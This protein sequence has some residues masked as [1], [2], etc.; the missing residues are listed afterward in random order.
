MDLIPVKSDHLGDRHKGDFLFLG[1]PAL[2]NIRVPPVRPLPYVRVSIKSNNLVT[3]QMR[4]ISQLL[5]LLPGWIGLRPGMMAQRGGGDQQTDGR[6]GIS[7]H[8]MVPKKGI[9]AG[10]PP[11]PLLRAPGPC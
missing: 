1:T 2:C 8:S 5:L 6:D 10:H 9:F 4:S 7:T 11:L 3:R